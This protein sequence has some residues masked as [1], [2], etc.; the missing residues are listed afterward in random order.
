MAEDNSSTVFGAT[1]N[2]LEQELKE[3]YVLRTWQFPMASFPHSS[4]NSAKVLCILAKLRVESIELVDGE[5]PPICEDVI[6]WR[7]Y[8][9]EVRAWVPFRIGIDKPDGIVSETEVST[10][11]QRL[12]DA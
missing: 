11:L 10:L 4:N 6:F 3:A 8:N 7:P 12:W 2:D 1:T 5:E 9:V